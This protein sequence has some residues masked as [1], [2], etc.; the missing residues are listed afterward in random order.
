MI[1]LLRIMPFRIMYVFSDGLYL[2]IYYAIGYR[3]NVVTANLGRSFPMKNE[4]EIK[5]L[6]KRFYHHLCDI[7]LESIKGFSMRSQEIIDRHFI[8]NPELADHYFNNNVSV[9]SVPG[10]YNNWEW[11]SLSPGLQIKSPIVGIYKPMTNKRVDAFVKKHRAKF[12][13]RLAPIRET[14]ITFKELSS[15][16]QTYIMAADQSPS[17]LKESHWFN[18]LNQKTAWLHGPE[19]YARM[20]NLPVIYV[21]IQKVKRGFYELKLVLLTDNPAA[22]PHGEITRLYAQHLE[23]TILKEPAYWLWSHKRWKH[24]G[25]RD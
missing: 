12:N 9:I 13:T 23:K 22:L 5:L 3:R 25:V 11:G 14:G 24:S 10:H 19:K 4:A 7:S 2:L 8:C 15:D 18:F 17:N 20:Y 16:P 21:D 6:T 1:I